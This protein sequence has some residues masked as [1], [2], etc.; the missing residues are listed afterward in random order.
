MLVRSVGAV[1]GQVTLARGNDL[2]PILTNE[3]PAALVLIAAIGL[4][5]GVE[6]IEIAITLPRRAN[7]L[8]GVA[9][10]V[11]AIDVLVRTV[12]TVQECIA[13]KHGGDT[14]IGQVALKH[15]WGTPLLIAAVAAIVGSVADRTH[16]SGF[17]AVRAGKT[18]APGDAIVETC[19]EGRLADRGKLVGA[20]RV[21]P[22]LHFAR[23]LRRPRRFTPGTGRDNGLM[24]AGRVR[25]LENCAPVWASACIPGV[26][27]IPGVA[28]VSRI[29][30]SSSQDKQHAQPNMQLRPPDALQPHPRNTS[31]RRNG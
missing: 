11:H 6:T 25:I 28:G 9:Y 21:D 27:R 31:F 3:R 19:G 8:P 1:R 23:F 18:P 20:A 29:C 26:A 15:E 4:V 30:T 2:A 5:G 7:F 24:A 12:E 14:V 13:F 16:E 22:A 10:K 17:N